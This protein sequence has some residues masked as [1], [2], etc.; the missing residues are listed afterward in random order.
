MFSGTSS[1]PVQ[2]SND[3]WS[4]ENDEFC[5][6]SDAC[7]IQNEDGVMIAM[8]CKLDGSQS[9]KFLDSEL[10]S[11]NC[12]LYVCRAIGMKRQ[13]IRSAIFLLHN[14]GVPDLPEILF[15]VRQRK[16]ENE[17]NRIPLAEVEYT[18]DS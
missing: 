10:S 18:Q 4:R 9:P 2:K 7:T 15:K 1:I 5:N 16:K 12:S 13:I 6:P 8:R 17:W 11:K 3:D 14:S